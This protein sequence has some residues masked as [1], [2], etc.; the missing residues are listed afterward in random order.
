MMIPLRGLLPL[1]PSSI[2]VLLDVQCLFTNQLDERLFVL[3]DHDDAPLADGV[4]P[5]V[6]LFVVA[7]ARAA[8]DEHVAIDDRPSDPRVAPDA[9]AGHQNAL[10]HIAEAVHANVRAEDASAD[11]AARDDAP[12]RDDRVERPATP[13]S[14]VG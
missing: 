5:P 13:A 7:D 6:F 1:R 2:E 9:H 11:G 14:L 4:A 3:G 12:G 10:L 8:R